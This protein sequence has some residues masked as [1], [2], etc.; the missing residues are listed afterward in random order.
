MLFRDLK[1]KFEFIKFGF[2]SIKLQPLATPCKLE[3]SVKLR[4][5]IIYMYPESSQLKIKS[6]SFTMNFKE[7]NSS[8]EIRFHHQREKDCAQTV[9]SIKA[10]RLLPPPTHPSFPIIACHELSHESWCLLAVAVNISSCVKL[11][12]LLCLTQSVPSTKKY[13]TKHAF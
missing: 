7:S 5:K 10:L 3:H 6:D 1:F 8:T 2:H 4:M 13:W 11:I 12:I 9:T